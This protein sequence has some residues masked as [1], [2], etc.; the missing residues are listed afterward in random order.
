LTELKADK[1]MY[2]ACP[3]DKCNKAVKDTGG[4]GQYRCDKCSQEF[5]NFHWRY[6]LRGAIADATD[7]EVILVIK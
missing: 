3:T 4:G 1:I 6:I 2:M 7:Y 5:P